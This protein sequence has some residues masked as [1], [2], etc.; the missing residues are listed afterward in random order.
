MAFHDLSMTSI[1][2]DGVNF[3]TYKGQHCLVVNVASECGMTRQ[4]EGLQELQN[5]FA[6]KGFTVLGFPC[7]QFGEQE[8]GTDAQICDFAETRYAVDF[9]MFSKVEVNG[10]AACELFRLL[11]SSKARPDGVEDIAWNFT[12]FLLDGDGNVIERFEPRV[13]P[14]QISERLEAL[15]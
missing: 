7:N 4:Y 5:D 1:R 11:K 2:G 3:S 6:S 14:A 12:K 13:T 15:L 8:P 9:P 10:D